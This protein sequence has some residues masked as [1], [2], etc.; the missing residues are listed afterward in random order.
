[1]G[2]EQAFAAC[3]P[4]KPP[5]FALDSKNGLPAKPA[6]LPEPPAPSS[7]KPRRPSKDK[8]AVGLPST[9]SRSVPLT[10]K[11][12]LALAALALVW[13]R[14]FVIY[15]R[16]TNAIFVFVA[17]EMLVWLRFRSGSRASGRA[18]GAK[19][20]KR[21]RGLSTALAQEGEAR[22]IQLI[23]E[24]LR[25]D[26]GLTGVLTDNDELLEVQLL[27]FVREHG[28]YDDKVEKR[29]RAM[30]EW[31]QKTFTDEALREQVRLRLR[32]VRLLG[33]GLGSGPGS[34]LGSGSGSGLGSG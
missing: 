23:R 28:L 26:A 30:L 22:V 24:R 1:M 7:P 11:I 29:F 21:E 31:K 27:R 12:G 6:A 9:P 2:L 19:P 25:A 34:G 32:L 5:A 3:L 16:T 20:A 8:L 17:I 18:V 4:K 33:S 10:V 13:R 15:S 14:L